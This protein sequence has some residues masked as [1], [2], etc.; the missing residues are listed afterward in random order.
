MPCHM[1]YLFFHSNRKQTDY[2]TKRQETFCCLENHA[3]VSAH[4]PF[5]SKAKSL[6]DISRWCNTLQTQG[7]SGLTKNYLPKSFLWPL[8]TGTLCTVSSALKNSGDSLIPDLS[9]IQ[10]AS[11][12]LSYFSHPLVLV[13]RE[14]WGNGTKWDPLRDSENREQ[15]TWRSLR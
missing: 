6:T 7:A 15:Q 8:S 1:A 10:L 12:S 5:G 4:F 9:F 2:L 14:L 11:L 3:P 13:L